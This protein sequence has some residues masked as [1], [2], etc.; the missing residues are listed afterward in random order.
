[1]F[2]APPRGRVAENRDPNDLTDRVPEHERYESRRS[3]W[4]VIRAKTFNQI[5]IEEEIPCGGCGVRCRET[6]FGALYIPTATARGIPYILCEACR[7]R[8][9]NPSTRDEVLNAV[10]LRLGPM[11][12][13][14]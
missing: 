12:G 6:R 2:S 4:G 3:R 1:M 7:V 8:V 5:N 10:G 11:L 13:A 14:A 9:L